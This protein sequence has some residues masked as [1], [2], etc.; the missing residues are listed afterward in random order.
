MQEVQYYRLF[1]WFH[2]RGGRWPGPGLICCLPMQRWRMKISQN[3]P[4]P[5]DFLSA[6]VVSSRAN[7][8]LEAKVKKSNVYSARLRRLR[9][10]NHVNVNRY[11]YTA[12]FSFI[13]LFFRYFIKT[14]YE[15]FLWC[16]PFSAVSLYTCR[17]F[18]EYD[19]NQFREQYK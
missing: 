8:C 19:N 4:P 6:L 16:E 5:S 11:S 1:E 15:I 2:E 9:Y 17:R 13:K 7:T 10:C 14:S 12:K 3:S 18:R